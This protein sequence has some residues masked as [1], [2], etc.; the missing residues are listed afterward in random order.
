M[1]ALKANNRASLRARATINGEHHNNSQDQRGG[2]WRLGANHPA[3]QRDTLR[4][5]S[6]IQASHTSHSAKSRGTAYGK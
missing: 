5:V 2:R 4:W 1:A 3:A 6:G